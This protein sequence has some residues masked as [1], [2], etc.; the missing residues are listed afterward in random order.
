MLLGI[1]I[2]VMVFLSVLLA[3]GALPQFCVQNV[4]F[5][6][7]RSPDTLEGRIGEILFYVNFM[8]PLIALAVLGAV[9]SV[10]T[11]KAKNDSLFFLLPALYFVGFLLMI[12]FTNTTMKH[13]FFYLTPYLVILS[14]MAFPLLREWLFGPRS[15][16]VATLAFLL[17]FGVAIQQTLSVTYTQTLPWFHQNNYN[18]V[19]YYVGKRVADLTSAND[20]IW[21][22]EG[23]IALYAD[24]LIAPPNS[25][26]F[27]WHMLFE[28]ELVN[29]SSFANGE[30]ATGLYSSEPLRLKQFAE[31]WQANHVKVIVM[32]RGR[33]WLPYPDELLWDGI[34][35]QEGV[36]NYVQTNFE[37]RYLITATN[38][39]QPSTIE[40]P[41]TYEIWERKSV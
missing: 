39:G 40:S 27:P 41:Y 1:A 23:A 29:S 8:L 15:R 3:Q 14:F 2:P 32:I 25:T 33:G 20:K 5:Q 6:M 35:G 24:R 16:K 30:V 28:F 13:Y 34:A 38:T 17:L 36:A 18:D 11:A 37:L 4:S 10:K 31:S 7:L 12:F 22:S 21:T 26:S 9:Y 19:E